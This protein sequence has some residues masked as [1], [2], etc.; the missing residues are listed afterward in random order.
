MKSLKTIS[1]SSFKI[2]AANREFSLYGGL[3]YLDGTPVQSYFSKNMFYWETEREC[4]ALY[5][6]HHGLMA[7][8]VL[9]KDGVREIHNASTEQHYTI[10]YRQQGKTADAAVDV[11]FGICFDTSQK[12]HYYC[13]LSYNGGEIIA[14]P[15]T[16]SE[17]INQRIMSVDVTEQDL[18]HIVIDSSGYKDVEAGFPIS[19]LDMVFDAT[20]NTCNA[21]ITEGEIKVEQCQASLELWEMQQTSPT[22]K[23]RLRLR[24]G[25]K[26]DLGQR[27]ITIAVDSLKKD[28]GDHYYGSVDYEQAQIVAMPASGEEKLAQNIFS[29]GVLAGKWRL[30]AKGFSSS[31]N[32]CYADS[33]TVWEDSLRPALVYEKVSQIVK[34][35]ATGHIKLTQALQNRDRRFCAD[36]LAAAHLKENCL[37]NGFDSA[38]LSVDDLFTLDAPP[39][40]RIEDPDNPGSYLLVDGQQHVHQKS[41]ELL[42]CLAAYYTAGVESS[43]KQLTYADLYGYTKDYAQTQI[44]QVSPAIITEIEAERDEN[45]KQYVVEFLKKF[46]DIILSSSYAGSSNEYIQKGFA[47][48]TDPV[49]RCQYYMADNHTGA[50]QHEKGYQ[51]AMSI[52]DRYVYMSMVPRLKEYY[53]ERSEQWAEDL[54]YAAL[55]RLV[56]LQLQTIGGSNRGTHL[57]KMLSILDS[58]KR[59]LRQSQQG[60]PVKDDDGKNVEMPYGAALYAQLFNLS[61]SEMGNSF[62][63]PDSEANFFKIMEVVFGDLY[64]K[65]A[66]GQLT[67]IP[68]DVL[69]ELQKVLEIDRDV[70]IVDQLCQ[71]EEFL[72]FSMLTSDLVS[73][74]V[75][76]GT[77]TNVFGKITFCTM[78]AMIGSSFSSVFTQ[79]DSLTD[80]EKAE[81]I[82]SCIFCIIGMAR[83]AV[84]WRS[85]SQLIDP[86]TPAEA[87]TQAAYRLKYGGTDLENIKNV[88]PQD[89][90][91]PY[92]LSQRLDSTSKQYSLDIHDPAGAKVKLS[93]CSKVFVCLEISFRVMNVLLLGYAFIMSSLSLAELFKYDYSEALRAVSV[94][95]TILLAVSFVLELVDMGIRFGI[96]AASA[97]IASLIPGIGLG[98]MLLTFAFTIAELILKKHEIKPPIQLIIEEHLSKTVAA[99]PEPPPDWE[100]KN[101]VLA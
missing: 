101:L 71:L 60:E 51:V 34:Y 2:H 40:M 29:C 3:L 73:S 67:D 95:N 56:M 46:S 87:R 99:L 15:K 23:G 92:D 44:F 13:G 91:N 16:D 75:K 55:D 33:L 63:G 37:A 14:V 35:S 100:Q 58:R 45:H 27:T 38:P 68:E 84:T 19:Q 9:Q 62:Q 50:M 59:V 78:Y 69:K 90:A 66:G 74:I 31:E 96:I 18:L 17:K 41:T 12:S 28:G 49:G 4:G 24:Y 65:I 20:Y 70:F 8:V 10:R 11:C 97:Q 76:Y 79:W 61:L 7:Q 30:S 82:L 32:G 83:E 42:S 26:V 80:A 89:P 52:I 54:Y 47:K 77:E 81:S 85:V 43:D 72:N 53:R 64:D 39:Q 94:I 57:A 21:T 98:V 86:S 6:Y 36:K 93:F 22:L 1:M 48:V 25:S 88:I 5:L